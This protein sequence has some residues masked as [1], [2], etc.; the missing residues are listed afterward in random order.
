MSN[1]NLPEI[2]TQNLPALTEQSRE[3]QIFLS[4]ASNEQE[5]H[6]VTAA[7]GT[8]LQLGNHNNDVMVAIL[9]LVAKWRALVGAYTSDQDQL[10]MECNY[11]VKYCPRLT[12][13]EL[14]WCIDLYAGQKLDIEHPKF[15]KFTPVFMQQVIYQFYLYKKELSLELIS[16]WER[17]PPPAAIPTAAEKADAMKYMI[18]EVFNQIQ[19]EAYYFYLLNSVYYFLYYKYQDFFAK[20]KGLRKQAIDYAMEKSGY[21]NTIPTDSKNEKQVNQLV[22]WLLKKED[23]QSIHLQFAK[24]YSVKE[25]FKKYTLD[26]VLVSVSESDFEDKEPPTKDSQE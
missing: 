5:K 1:H 13:Q 2:Q 22:K 25:F 6:L 21:L 24:E 19:A 7:F 11:L 9:L 15:F 3:Q 18:R 12:V 17:L 20:T 4:L 10:I 26:E 14:N 8:P 23:Q 16:K